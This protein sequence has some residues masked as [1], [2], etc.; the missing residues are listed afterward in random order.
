MMQL[1]YLE[2]IIL[3][4][5]FLTL[6]DREKLVVSALDGLN[7]LN[8]SFVARPKIITA[9]ESD[10]DVIRVGKLFVYKFGC[11]PYLFLLKLKESV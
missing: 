10:F 4:K 5:K 7:D 2:F 8:W 6:A 3:Y 1:T 9:Q 11:I